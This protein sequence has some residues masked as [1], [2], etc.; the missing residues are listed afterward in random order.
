MHPLIEK[1]EARRTADKEGIEPFGVGDTVDVYV[2]IVEDDKKR[3]QK[4]QGTVIR[5]RGSGLR[6]SFT[7]RKISFGEGV[8]RT[9]QLHSPTVKKVKNIRKGKVRRAK[10]YYLRKEVGKKTKLKEKK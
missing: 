6:E 9:F 4:F 2:E 3:I 10:L 1:I 7:V 8:E 5:K